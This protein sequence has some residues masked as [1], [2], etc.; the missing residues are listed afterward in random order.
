MR[1]LCLC[2]PLGC[3]WLAMRKCWDCHWKER[4][5][6]NGQMSTCRT[7]HV[8]AVLV[9]DNRV[10]AD[11]FNGNL[12][13]HTHCDQGGCPRCND[14]SVRSGEQLD[15]CFCVHAEQ[16]IF[17]Y[18]AKY[19]ISTEGTTIHLPANSCLDCWKLC[20]AAG[21]T[22]QVIGGKYPGAYETIMELAATS[23]ITVREFRCSCG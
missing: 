23:G 12:P 14:P 7:R 20:V 17:A 5:E 2:A 11:G 10:V 9:R 4:V 6:A 1:W 19:G 22:E 15:R 3:C 21:I 8:G 13:G 18:C 16:N